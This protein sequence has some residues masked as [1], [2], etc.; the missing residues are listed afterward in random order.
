M[1]AKRL[2]VAVA[3]GFVT[4]IICVLLAVLA[5]KQE[6]TVF[7]TLYVLINRTLAGVI[8][9]ISA[10]R[11]GWFKHGALIGLI[12]SLPMAAGGMLYPDNVVVVIATVILGVIYG[13]I[14]EFFT[15]VVFSAPSIWS[16]SR[17]TAKGFYEKP[18]PST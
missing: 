13:I 6:Y 7:T 1:Y 4:A 10:I 11:L 3:F 18:I 14:I 12:A 5:L 9:G 2:I 16:P 17:Q 15:S 8:I